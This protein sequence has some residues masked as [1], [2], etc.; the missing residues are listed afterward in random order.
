MPSGV[1]AD[2]D[3]K[4]KSVEGKI[5]Q[6]DSAVE[7]A[8]AAQTEARKKLEQIA[9]SPRRPRARSSKKKCGQALAVGGGRDQAHRRR[10]A[11]GSDR[12]R[13][14]DRRDRDPAVRER[15][16]ARADGRGGAAAVG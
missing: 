8:E 6:A 3:K 2:L 1:V 11:Q 7:K 16:R 10:R 4:E 14:D 15:V 12:A 5:K 9:G 13:E